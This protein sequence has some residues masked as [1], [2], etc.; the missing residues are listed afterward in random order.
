M[1]TS[2]H[3]SLEKYTSHFIERVVCERE[4][5]TEQNCNILTPTLMAITA[6][7]SCSS[8]LLNRGP[9]GPASLGHVSHSSI[10][11]PTGLNSNW[12][13]RVSWGPPLLGAGSIYSILSPTDWSSCRRGYIIIWCPLS[14][15]ECHNFALNSTPRQS[16]IYPDIPRPDAPVIH[17]GAFPILTA[18]PGRRS[19]C[20]TAR[21]L[22]I[23]PW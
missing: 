4:F 17:T 2:R 1:K 9:E 16:R 22:R 21:V 6:F 3:T 12:L 15:C 7:L 13:N 8:G 18:W 20:N 11:S 23:D 14:S 5:E 19:I 10:F